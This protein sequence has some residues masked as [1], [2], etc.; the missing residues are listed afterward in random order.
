MKGRT[1]LV[2]AIAVSPPPCHSLPA[3]SRKRGEGALTA[4]RVP[5]SRLREK[6]ARGAG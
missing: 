2:S 1:G 6:V 3:L 5:F 4:E